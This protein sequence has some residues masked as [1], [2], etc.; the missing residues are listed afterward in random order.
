MALKINKIF[1][2]RYP[3]NF[4]I[5]KPIIGTLVFLICIFTFIIIYQPLHVRNARSFS[6][7]LTIL[8]Y[9][10]IFSTTIFILTLILKK[11]RF[12]SE[13]ETWTFF[14]ELLFDIII[15]FGI[16]ISA[17]FAG[18]VIEE[19]SSR[20]NLPTFL[21]SFQRALFLGVIPI[22]LFTL[23]NIRYLFNPLIFQ[24]YTTSSKENE[25][26]TETLINITSKAK[27]EEL[28]FY[29]D[30]FI[31]AESRGNYIVFHLFA[32][33]KPHEVII[34]NSIS[35]IEQQFTKIP[36]FI[37]V[38]RA[39]I[40]NLKKVKSKNGNTLGYRLKLAGY[41]DM[42]PVSR[43]NISRFDQLIQLYQ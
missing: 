4:L 9:C 24:D 26:E 15:L 30:Q 21:D 28:S 36:W 33:D 35:N 3:Q 2:E 14:K 29:A 16:S 39:Y 43:Q 34:R 1:K 18:F 6:F 11:I 32:K 13:H 38:H 23:L 31:Y 19:P 7:H 41:S 37:R 22:F 20:W 12:F 17:Y 10:L 40:V 8:L 42:V 5:K 25:K 27:K